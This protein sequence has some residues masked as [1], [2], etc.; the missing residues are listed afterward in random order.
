MCSKGLFTRSNSHPNRLC[1]N[2]PVSQPTKQTHLQLLN[3]NLELQAQQ[4]TATDLPQPVIAVPTPGAL[5][6]S[7]DERYENPVDFQ[8]STMRA[9]LDKYSMGK[10]FVDRSCLTLGPNTRVVTMEGIL[11][12]VE[13]IKAHGYLQAGNISIVAF[14]SPDGR[15]ANIDIVRQSPDLIRKSLNWEL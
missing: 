13:S 11:K 14:N 12:I 1:L 7:T 6:K 15:F 8:A 9:L 3:A 4:P 5:A 2:R 10:H